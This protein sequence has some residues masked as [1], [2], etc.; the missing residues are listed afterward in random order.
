VVRSGSRQDYDHSLAQAYTALRQAKGLAALFLR[1]RAHEGGVGGDLVGG[2]QTRREQDEQR[3][4]QT[5]L[6]DKQGE[7]ATRRDC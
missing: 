4:E 1:R 6:Q 5:R 3:T 7:N 2:G